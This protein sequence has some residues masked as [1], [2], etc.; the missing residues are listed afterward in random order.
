M[1]VKLENLDRLLKKI[2]DKIVDT[3]TS[4]ALVNDIG[5]KVVED[6]KI[7]MSKQKMP[8]GKGGLK[9]TPRLTKKTKTYYR[10]RGKSDQPLFDFSGE[11]K[12]SLHY[13][14][15]KNTIVIESGSA[16]GKK[17]L[18]YLKKS[19]SLS[20]KRTMRTFMS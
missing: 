1:N 12:Q 2:L 20:I 13:R 9:K 11:L 16:K 5:T 19:G 14:V 8:D 10:S 18:K 17:K 6:L 15:K 3:L 7:K 4:A